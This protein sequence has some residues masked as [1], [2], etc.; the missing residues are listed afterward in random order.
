METVKQTRFIT[1]NYAQLQGLRVIP[2]ALA[3]IIVSLWA[4]QQSG[5]SSNLT[6]PLTAMPVCIFLYVLVDRYYKRTYGRIKRPSTSTEIMLQLA[7]AILALSAFFIDSTGRFNFSFLSLIFAIAIATNAFHYYQAIP[8]LFT[9]TLIL[10]VIFLL[11]T[12][13]PLAGFPQ[14]WQLFGLK[15]NLLTLSF[16]Y[17][18]F[19]LLSGLITHFYF[20][21][22]L[23]SH[24]EGK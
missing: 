16:F 11:L 18:I 17:G 20:V 1:R 21:N 22:S 8:R 19:V 24:L 23:P 15:N 2:F 4:N 7:A 13:L 6:L 12:F 9:A 5:S 10:A 3:M 14:W